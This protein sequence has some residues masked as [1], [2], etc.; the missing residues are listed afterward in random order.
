[1]CSIY[2]KT[3]YN[4]IYNEINMSSSHKL[5]RTLFPLRCTTGYRVLSTFHTKFYILIHYFDAIDHMLTCSVFSYV[6]PKTSLLMESKAFSKSTKD[7]Y[8]LP[9]IALKYLTTHFDYENT[10]YSSS[11]FSKSHLKNGNFLWCNNQSLCQ[12]G[13]IP[14]YILPKTGSN[15]VPL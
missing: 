5:D 6:K 3:F 12:S 7:K 2:I 4:I 1:M 10:I 13:R 9:L 15:E 11:A 8:N 14:E